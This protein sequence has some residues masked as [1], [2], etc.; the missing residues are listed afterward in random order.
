MSNASN[1]GQAA[2]SYQPEHWVRERRALTPQTPFRWRVCCIAHTLSM[3]INIWAT[4]FMFAPLASHP[5]DALIEE[6]Q[7]EAFLEVEVNIMGFAPV[8]ASH[9]HLRSHD[10][11]GKHTGRVPI[12][13]KRVSAIANTIQRSF[14]NNAWHFRHV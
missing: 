5:E 2:G 3:S 7:V 9:T 6:H 14:I 13:T 12:C 11:I 4:V 10:G 1:G 8:T